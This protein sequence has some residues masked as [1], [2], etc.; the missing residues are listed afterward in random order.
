MTYTRNRGIAAISL[1]ADEVAKNSKK[2]PS[3]RAIT[4]RAII[5]TIKNKENK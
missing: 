1:L 3:D 5:Q 2:L 4:R